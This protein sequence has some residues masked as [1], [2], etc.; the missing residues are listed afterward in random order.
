[1][2]FSGTIVAITPRWLLAGSALVVSGAG[3]LVA[4]ARRLRRAEGSSALVGTLEALSRR[5]R[6][7]ASAD[8]A[9][10]GEV[11]ALARRSRRAIG[12]AAIVGD[13]TAASGRRRGATAQVRGVVTVVG[14]N[15]ARAQGLLQWA[16][17]T[18]A[19]FADGSTITTY[20]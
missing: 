19:T 15:S 18:D 14:T 8:V 3:A 11:S 7:A 1:M 17:G 9:F 6:R 5:L 12:E 16:D 2:A 13:L 4:L 10:V 20:R